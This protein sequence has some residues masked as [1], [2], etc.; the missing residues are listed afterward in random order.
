[1]HPAVFKVF[2]EICCADKISG[3]VLEIGAMPDDSTLLNLSSLAAA[4]EKIGINK[5]GEFHFKD[6]SFSRLTPTT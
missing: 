5:S 6:F 1:M 4:S 2:E 3:A